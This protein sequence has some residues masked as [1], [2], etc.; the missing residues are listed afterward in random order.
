MTFLLFLAAAVLEIGGCWLVWLAM[1]GGPAWFWLPA[2]V[3][4]TLF[5]YLLSL[6]GTESAGRAFAVY[7]GIYILGSVA[8]MTGVEGVRPDRWDLIGAGFALLGAAVIFW[9]PRGA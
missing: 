1:R 3:S 7:G 8:F 9:G 5:G 2:I 6:T 4:L